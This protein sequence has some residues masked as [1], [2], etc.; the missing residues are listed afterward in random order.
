MKPQ[1]TCRSKVAML[2]GEGPKSF[3]DSKQRIW[4]CSSCIY[5]CKKNE[6]GTIGY[7]CVE[8]KSNET[9]KEVSLCDFI[10]FIE[11]KLLIQI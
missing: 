11:K 2:L 9:I 8:M 4:H 3:V 1:E 10:G 5:P 6:D 7:S